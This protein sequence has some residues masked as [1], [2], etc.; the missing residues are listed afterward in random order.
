[1]E[2]T[3]EDDLLL[4]QLSGQT[5]QNPL[6]RVPESHADHR[7]SASSEEYSLWLNDFGTTLHDRF[8]NDQ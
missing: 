7:D 4:T 2:S 6:M 3:N 1:M 8:A 5:G